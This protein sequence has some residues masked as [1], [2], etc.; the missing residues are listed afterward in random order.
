[1]SG[2][3]LTTDRLILTPVTVSDF[4]DQQALW[5]EEA[6]TRAIAGRGPFSR[7][8]V[9][10]RLLRDLGHWQVMGRGNWAMRL[11]TTGTA[12][13]AYVGSVGVLHFLRDCTP[14]M[15][16]PEL[17]WGIGGAFQGQGLAREGL[18][19]ALAWADRHLDEPRSVCMIN[20]DNAP[21]LKLAERVGYRPYTDATYHNGPVILLERPRQTPSPYAGH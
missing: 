18:E 12:T 20:P 17:G 8:E 16:A 3:V 10:F 21:S 1:M 11:R 4:E 2:P 13:G 5:S 7:E 6:F 9:W 15:D 19:A 14:P